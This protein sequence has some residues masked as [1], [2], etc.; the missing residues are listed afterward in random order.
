MPETEK[1]SKI[2]AIAE[3][4]GIIIALAGFLLL[5]SEVNLNLDSQTFWAVTFTQILV[6]LLLFGLG[7]TIISASKRLEIVKNEG[8]MVF[9]WSLD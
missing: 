7:S 2:R 6:S 1:T 9:Y 5:A 4:I 8:K 3:K